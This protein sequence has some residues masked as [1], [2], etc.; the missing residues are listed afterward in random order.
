[1]V[2][3]LIEEALIDPFII[4]YTLQW[5]KLNEKKTDEK[6]AD[7]EDEKESKNEK[8]KPLFDKKDL[9][10]SRKSEEEQKFIVDCIIK[11]RIFRLTKK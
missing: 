9:D 8:K 1:M 11:V 2:N 3:F 4:K 10:W 5:K 7:E 6:K